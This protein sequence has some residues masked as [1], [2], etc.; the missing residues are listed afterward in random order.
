M[1]RFVAL[2]I[3]GSHSDLAGLAK[4]PV[5]QPV[6]NLRFAA[7]RFA[8]TAYGFTNPLHGFA[9][10]AERRRVCTQPR[11]LHKSANA[12]VQDLIAVD[13]QE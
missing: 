4:P 5:L 7:L 1:L 3:T 6:A 2:Q 12:F 13:L 11:R 8:R 10:Q 9:V